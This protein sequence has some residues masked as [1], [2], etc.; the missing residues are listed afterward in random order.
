MP[1]QLISFISNW[2]AEHYRQKIAAADFGTSRVGEKVAVVTG[3]A[4]G[5]GLGLAEEL[6]RDGANV[7]LADINASKADEEAQRLCEIYGEGKVQ[8][9]GVDVGDEQSVRN[10]MREAALLFGGLDLL[11]S[12]AGVLKAGG[13]EDMNLA[14]FESVTH[15]NYTAFFLCVKYASEIMK[16]QH[17]CNPGIMM[18][19]VQINSKS[20]LKGSNR[21]FAYAGSKF[22]GLGLIQ[23][24]ALE[25]IEH[26]IKV[27]AICPGNYFEGPLWS[28]PERGLFVQYL[29]A[30]KVAGAKSPEDVR[31]YYENQVPMGRGCETKDIARALFYIVEQQYETGQAVPV[32]GGQIMLA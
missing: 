14:S 5:I 32:T 2:E 4:Q 20:G 3:G 10:L 8:A 31:R 19:I 17:R 15:I 1:E 9:V 29:K 27:N 24:F 23:S 22:G 26:N 11:V 6:V 28:D 13:L 18:D 7:I 30:G 16:I 25:L 21:N 12:N